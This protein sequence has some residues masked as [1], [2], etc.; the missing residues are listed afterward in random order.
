MLIFQLPVC[1][2]DCRCLKRQPRCELLQQIFIVASMNTRKWFSLIWSSRVE[3]YVTIDGQSALRPVF[4]T[5]RQLQVCLYAALSLMRGWGWGLQ[6]LLGLASAVIRG[7][8]SHWARDH[9]LLP[10][11]RDLFLWRLLRVAEL[12][13]RKST[14]PSHVIFSG[15]I[16]FFCY[17]TSGRTARENNFNTVSKETSITQRRFV[18]KNLSLLE[19]VYR[20]VA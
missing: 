12:R 20:V 5:V 18:C 7:C 15:L 13:W 10:Q 14:P 4:I 2:W 19:R 11:I 17:I 1:V 9:I 6:L 16:W 3:F 8:E